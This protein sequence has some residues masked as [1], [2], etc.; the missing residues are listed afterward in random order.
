MVIV[1]SA[2]VNMSVQMSLGRQVTLL[3]GTLGTTPVLAA[4][5]GFHQKEAVDACGMPRE[6]RSTV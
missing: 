5:Q 3:I 1:N 4:S 6:G 2:A